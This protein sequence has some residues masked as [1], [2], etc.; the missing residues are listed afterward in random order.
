[1]RPRSSDRSTRSRL[2]GAAIRLASAIALASVVWACGGEESPSP[3]SKPQEPT[4]ALPAPGDTAAAPGAMPAAP[5]GGA[6]GEAVANDGAIPE[7]Y[8]SDV[9]VYPGAT[10]G[11]SMSM[12]GLGVF[13]TFRSGDSAKQIED[14][15]RTELAKGGWSVQ[16][17]PDGG[18]LDGTKGSRSVQVR[19]RE[20]NQPGTEIAISFSEK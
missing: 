4:Q 5:S 17:S 2:A 3:G 7:G 6:A 16:D 8:P 12:P 13:A 1:M 14:Y 10:P 11:S 19:A 18:G 9:P 15:Y 20:T